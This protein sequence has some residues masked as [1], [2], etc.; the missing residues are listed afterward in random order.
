MS[1]RACAL[2]ATATVVVGLTIADQGVAQAGP[3]ASSAG[4]SPTIATPTPNFIC[5]AMI[6][7]HMSDSR[8]QPQI[9]G[10]PHN[11]PYSSTYIIHTGNNLTT[12]SITPIGGK[13]CIHLASTGSGGDN[14]T[15]QSEL[16]GGQVTYPQNGTNYG[17]CFTGFNG[18]LSIHFIIRNLGGPTN[19]QTGKFSANT[20]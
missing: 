1:L 12:D 6:T 18:D 9:G 7:N 16:G 17:H 10:G 20:S 3:L 11:M 2:L 8:P 13:I 19:P 5:P 15:V 4:T 14:V